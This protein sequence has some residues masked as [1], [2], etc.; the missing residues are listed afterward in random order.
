MGPQIQ[1]E[2]LLTP[3]YPKKRFFNENNLEQHI[4]KDPR[5]R[6]TV[7][8]KISKGKIRKSPTRFQLREETPQKLIKNKTHDVLPK[9]IPEILKLPI[10]KKDM[11]KNKEVIGS[12]PSINSKS[13]LLKTTSSLFKSNNKI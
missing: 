1:K 3:E 7:G 12:K 8:Q 4:P 11:N 6:L 2:I 10:L 5:E 9:N 13:S